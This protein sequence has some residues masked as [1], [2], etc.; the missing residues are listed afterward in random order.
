MRGR[1]VNPPEEAA[2]KI[3]GNG[4]ESFGNACSRR[5][6]RLDVRFPVLT[7]EGSGGSRRE[8]RFCRE[9]VERL[10]ASSSGYE[11]ARVFF[12][13]LSGAQE[14]LRPHHY[15]HYSA[16]IFNP[17]TLCSLLLS[18]ASHQKSIPPGGPSP[19][20]SRCGRRR[21]MERSCLPKFQAKFSVSRCDPQ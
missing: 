3:P 11:E 15:H 1:A 6:Q 16:R 4:K 17:R 20:V 18:S 7:R 9:I 10:R 19:E 13:R 12:V 2:L 14:H 21:C 8:K 5:R